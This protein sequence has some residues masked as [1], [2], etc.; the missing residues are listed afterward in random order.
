MA[1]WAAPKWNEVSEEELQ[2]LFA[3]HTPKPKPIFIVV[4]IPIGEDAEEVRA[5]LENTLQ[6][7]PK[8]K[9]K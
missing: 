1:K 2:G 8:C 6:A 7:F 4:E 9:L 3:E 5:A